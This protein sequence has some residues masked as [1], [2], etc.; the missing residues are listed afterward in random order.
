MDE[1]DI[2]YNAFISYRHTEL[3]IYVAENLHKLLESFKVPRIADKK[4]KE[5]GKQKINRVFR[6]KDELPISCDLNDPI[7]T[8]LKS[9]EFLIVICSPRVK[10]SLWVQREIEAFAKFHGHDRILAV[11]V[12]GEPKDAF[13]EVLCT[14]EKEIQCEDGTVKTIKQEIEPLAAD[15]RG[16]NKK[17]IYKKLKAELI[18]LAAPIL[19]CS[20]DDLKQRH[21]EQKLRNIMAVSFV[22]SIVFLLFGSYSAIQALRIQKQSVEISE[23]AEIIKK[24][25]NK[26]MEMLSKAL[27]NEALGLL[28][29]GDRMGAILLA[30]EALPKNLEQMERPLV[31]KGQYALT[32]A[33]QVYANQNEFLPDRLLE[34]TAYVE[35]AK[36]SPEGTTITS[37]DELGYIYIWNADNGSLM[38]KSEETY[39]IDASNSI[40]YIDENSIILG[41]YKGVYCIDIT[42]MKILWKMDDISVN[43]M[44][45]SDDSSL[46]AIGDGSRIVVVNTKS[47]DMI[48]HKSQ[49]E[50]LGG[51]YSF[52][53]NNHYLAYPTTNILSEEAGGIEV[54][55][56]KTKHIVMEVSTVYPWFKSLLISDDGVLYAACADKEFTSKLGLYGNNRLYA[57]SPS[58]EE[59]WKL[60]TSF[61]ISN[62]LSS[63]EENKDIVLFSALDRIILVSKEDGS[64]IRE[65]AYTSNI[66]NYYNIEASNILVV[67]LNDGSVVV[68]S[69]IDTEDYSK[70]YLKTNLSAKNIYHNRDRMVVF[71]YY[72]NNLYL[73]KNTLAEDAELMVNLEKKCYKASYDKDESKLAM[74]SY[75]S[76][77]LSLY[78]CKNKKQ[79]GDIRIDGDKILNYWFV[80]NDTKLIIMGEK[81]V[82]LY[83]C[84]SLS[85]LS[86]VK[87]DFINAAIIKNDN[88]KI[89]I[90]TYGKVMVYNSNTLQL[91]KEYETDTSL[92]QMSFYNNEKFIVGYTMLGE[93]AI[94]DLEADNWIQCKWNS[95]LL[96]G[97]NNSD[98]YVIVNKDK[99]EV[100]LYRGKS[101]SPQKVI[102]ENVNLIKYIGFSPK[103]D[104]LFLTFT[105]KLTKIYKTEDLTL[106]KTLR[107]QE[108]YIN[109]WIQIGDINI[110]TDD[111]ISSE[112]YSYFCNKKL[113]KVAKLPNMLTM[114]A[115][116]KTVIIGGYG[117]VYN[118]PV[119][120][121][122]IL[123]EKAK[124]HL[125]GRELTKEERELYFI[126]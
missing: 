107:E 80:D 50:S 73:Y 91:E 38:N 37:V 98:E 77:V 103:D 121:L 69:I 33:L 11:L 56:L 118:I 83:D 27:A 102:N 86:E 95:K 46:A 30:L 57:F 92:S 72:S 40:Y 123:L 100:Q 44:K 122:D 64:I 117:T 17:A 125:N 59:I 12:E 43:S 13:P 94:L 78:D 82:Y 66:T 62:T 74:I 99:Q 60:D 76:N 97:S 16:K 105:N 67:S 36:L 34:H 75:M 85:K 109:Q 70:C 89:Y 111:N 9:S 113:E 39:E 110:F 31:A 51:I 87:L 126:D 3:D 90:S 120:Q 108:N 42:S 5:K 54:V 21:K 2:K 7:M 61:P 58:G 48:Y 88:S 112:G 119:Y 71:P 18:R 24:E 53:P 23:K 32:E 104:Y 55:D 28:A 1:R 19:G 96:A 52:S 84:K 115:N 8:A 41:G 22:C 79:I 101:K 10:E 47:G 35:H 81:T 29:E 65:I 26:N 20:Y 93:G 14:V 49:G 15:V 68:T 6:D 25:N 4:L 114:T 63:F 106:E 45:L 124:E 116:A